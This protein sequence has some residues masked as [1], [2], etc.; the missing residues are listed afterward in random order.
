MPVAAELREHLVDRDEDGNC[1]SDLAPQDIP[2]YLPSQL[3]AEVW[4]TGCISGLH[5]LELRYRLAQIS[6]ALAELKT[7]LCV[8]SSLIQYKISSVNGEGQRSLTRSRNMLLA[9]KEKAEQLANRYRSV[10]ES[11]VVLEPQGSWRR[12]FDVLEPKDIQAPNGLSLDNN[13]A[14]LEVQANK[15]RRL[16]SGTGEGSR[17]ISWIWNVCA[18]DSYVPAGDTE[19]EMSKEELD[20]REC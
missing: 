6:D 9:T 7:Q 2:L 16:G 1:T 5:N 8:Y 19:M 14:S 12:K 20:R 4:R 3:P 15:R 18:H 10:R 13:E 11:L 17:E